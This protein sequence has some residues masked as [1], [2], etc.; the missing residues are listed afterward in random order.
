MK[1]NKKA[2][3]IICIL[4]AMTM[5]VAATERSSPP[6]FKNL[7][8]LPKNISNEDLDKIMD[9]FKYALNVKCGY[10]H[11]RNDS[12]KKFDFVSDAKPEK[13]MAR[14]MMRMTANIN[15]KYFNFKKEKTAPEVVTC[16]TCHRQNPVPVI[17]SSWMKESH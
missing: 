2:S 16:I 11:A 5:S 8:V 12:T 17:D 6:V 3:V 7:K 15:K 13:E 4:A 9:K 10:C 1:I 14:D